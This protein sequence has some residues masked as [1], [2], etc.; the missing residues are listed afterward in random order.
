M[1]AGCGLS[2]ASVNLGSH[3]ASKQKN[4]TLCG[5]ENR[6]ASDFFI[7]IYGYVF[8]DLMPKFFKNIAFVL[9]NGYC[10]IEK[11]VILCE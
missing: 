3:A 11:K 8:T 2:A 4:K 5:C 10:T 6:Y 9:K 7:F 1:K